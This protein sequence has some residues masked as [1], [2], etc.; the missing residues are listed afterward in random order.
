MLHRPNLIM[1]LDFKCAILDFAMNPINCERN[2]NGNVP[3][4]F[5]AVSMNEGGHRHAEINSKNELCKL[6][7][8]LPHTVSINNE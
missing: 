5:D 1:L 2:A 6:D 7:P 8:P 4:W 3:C